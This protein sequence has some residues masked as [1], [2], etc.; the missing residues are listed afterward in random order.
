MELRRSL[1]FRKIVAFLYSLCFAIYLI[2]GFQPA[3]EATNYEV[4]S[5]L[6]IPAISLHTD[7]TTLKL[8][9][10]KLKTPDTIVGSFTQNENKTLLIGHAST[11]FEKLKNISLGDEII[12]DFDTYIVSDIKVLVKKDVDMDDILAPAEIQTIIIMTC[13]GDDLGNGDSTHRLIVTAQAL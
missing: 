12:Y 8:H 4:S 5:E 6:K 3:A 9:N 13:A 1:N 7:V 2:I 11:V 10:R